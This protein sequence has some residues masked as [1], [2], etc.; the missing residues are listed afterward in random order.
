VQALAEQTRTIPV[1]PGIKSVNVNLTA[2]AAPP[3]PVAIRLYG[4]H[5]HVTPYR[6]CLSHCGSGLIKVAQP[7]P[8]VV[9]ITMT[10]L[11]AAIG[12]PCKPAVAEIDFDL[13]QCLEVLFAAPEVKRGRLTIEGRLIGLLR[14]ACCGGGAAGESHP[15]AVI[16]VEGVP[17]DAAAPCAGPVAGS[18]PGEVVSVS[19]PDHTVA[20]GENLSIND[21]CGPVSVSITAAKYALHGTWHL[22]ATESCRLPFCKAGSA[23]F[24]PAPALDPVWVS[25]WEPF[26][27]VIKKDF[28]FQI[29]LRVTEDASASTQARQQ[30]NR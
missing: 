24:A 13:N 8:D 30:Q 10:G 5:G 28:G 1:G 16:T 2:A 4:R 26:H 15:A 23:E 12:N 18:P 11:A 27:G 25:L 29:V 3:P 9:V 19:L 7:S 22:S 21:H 20:G 6:C 17:A 14:S